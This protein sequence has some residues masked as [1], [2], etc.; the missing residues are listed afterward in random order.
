M[1]LHSQLFWGHMWIV[2]GHT[3]AVLH[4]ELI[5]ASMYIVLAD[6]TAISKA[7]VHSLPAHIAESTLELLFL[8]PAVRDGVLDKN[9]SHACTGCCYIVHALFVSDK[10]A[11]FA[12]IAGNP[13]MLSTVMAYTA[14]SKR[15]LVIRMAA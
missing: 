1:Q 6:F 14:R 10:P 3:L 11:D 9:R 5:T 15:L 8:S 12:G 4:A 7:V 2:R 13:D